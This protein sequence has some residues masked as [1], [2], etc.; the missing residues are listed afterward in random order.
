MGHSAEYYRKRRGNTD[1]PSVKCLECG[2]MFIIIGVH[3][4]YKHKMTAL[5]YKLKHNLLI[6]QGL[7]TPRVKAIK[8]LQAKTNGT[9]QNILKDNGHRLK[10]KD[11]RIAEFQ[12]TRPHYAHRQGIKGL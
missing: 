11:K 1:T 5:Q 2:Q 10:P 7:I 6:N 9:M 8:A 4:V 12:A 3:L